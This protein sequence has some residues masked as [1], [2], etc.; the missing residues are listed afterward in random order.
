MSQHLSQCYKYSVRLI[1]FVI[2]DEGRSQSIPIGQEEGQSY[3]PVDPSA[4][5]DRQTRRP[6]RLTSIPP[7]MFRD[8]FASST[9]STSS[10]TMSRETPT[11]ASSTSSFPSHAADPSATV[12]GYHYA[13]HFN[14]SRRMS[15]APTKSAF[16][17]LAM[18]Q[19]RAQAQRRPSVPLNVLLQ[20][21]SLSPSQNASPSAESVDM[22][23]D[24]TGT[25]VITTQ[26]PT[27]PSRPRLSRYRS[28]PDRRLTLAFTMSD[29]PA[30]MTDQRRP[31]IASTIAPS[32]SRPSVDGPDRRRSR[33]SSGMWAAV[34]VLDTLTAPASPPIS[35]RS[36]SPE[37]A[38]SLSP[39]SPASYAARKGSGGSRNL[40]ISTAMALEDGTSFRR[41]FDSVDSAFPIEHVRA[42]QVMSAGTRI[43]GQE[44][45]VTIG[46]LSDTDWSASFP[47]RG[48]L[49]VLGNAP[50]VPWAA[51]EKKGIQVELAQLGR[52]DRRGSWVEGWTLAED[53]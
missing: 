50:L 34:D 6:S 39:S 32:S 4:V 25:P 53:A 52:S 27:S 24:S 13:S 38:R 19:A 47:R 16:A 21:S 49:L 51:N 35:H 31:S 2:R 45:Q 9:P 28:L 14:E 15:E 42:D 7:T 33:Q 5:V 1:V 22:E 3:A 12:P 17:S 11:S 37:Q 8:P 43:S 10:S 36:I 29:A 48:S 23:D 26:S 44:L 18:A 40:A 30:P 41:R 20:S 46:P